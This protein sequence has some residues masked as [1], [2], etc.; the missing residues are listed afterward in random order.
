MLAPLKDRSIVKRDSGH[1]LDEE[2]AT[3]ALESPAEIAENRSL[4][5]A[6]RLARK[7]QRRSATLAAREIV[8]L[9]N[10]I[11]RLRQLNQTLQ[12]KIEEHE[13]GQAITSLGQRLLALSEANEHLRETAQR[14]WYLDKTL[15]AAHH[16]CERLVEERNAAMA[17]L[18]PFENK[19]C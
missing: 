6:L 1:P 19:C 4:R 15:C 7:E 2:N 3:P 16:E 13:S 5:E 18:S 14:V 11:N 17:H 12:Q 8:A 9:T 10:E